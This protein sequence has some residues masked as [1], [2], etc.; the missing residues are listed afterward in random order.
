MSLD[1]VVI[2]P[3]DTPALEFRHLS[4][5]YNKQRAID[6]ITVSIA[7]GSRVGLIGPNGAGKSTLLRSIV[8]LLT[9][10]N[11]QVR[12]NGKTDRQSRREAAYVPQFEDVDWEFP[13]S[14]LD[15]VV[16]GLA[17]QVGWLRLPNK[18][19]I[20]LAQEALRRVGLADYADR[21]IGQLS[22]G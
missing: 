8:G 13:V 1:K 20:A 10:L 7:A 9:P 21:Q 15:V 2:K 3:V 16:M 19:H 14:V 5:G 4:A 18:H 17:R 12:I 22:G 6:D 11:G